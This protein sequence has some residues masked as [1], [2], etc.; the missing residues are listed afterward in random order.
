MWLAFLCNLLVSPLGVAATDLPQTLYKEVPYQQQK[1]CAN[2]CF[3][4]E[5]GWD[6]I[7]EE[8]SCPNVWGGAY[9]SCYCRLDNMPAAGVHLSSC[10]H[11]GCA[12]VGG[13]PSTDIS[14]ANYLYTSYC[15]AKGFVVKGVSLGPTTTATVGE[16]TFVLGASGGSRELM[17]DVRSSDYSSAN[18]REYPYLTW[19][20]D[21]D[22]SFRFNIPSQNYQRDCVTDNLS[23][24]IHCAE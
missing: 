10:I 16:C 9:D 17:L 15:N 18:D 2:R 23:G 22:D 11:S 21:T 8:L 24:S 20:R 3:W 12:T 5:G 13:D 1:S 19:C 4:A 7:G 6:L 14:T